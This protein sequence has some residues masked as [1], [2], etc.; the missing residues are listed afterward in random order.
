[1]F[2]GVAKEE[3]KQVFRMETEKKMIRITAL[4]KDVVVLVITTQVNIYLP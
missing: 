3:E 4:C 2:V 1:M